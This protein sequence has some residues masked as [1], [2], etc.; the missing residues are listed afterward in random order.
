[1]IASIIA[2]RTADDDVRRQARI[3]QKRRDVLMEGLERIGWPADKPLASMFVWARV[4]D[5]HLA[6]RDSI[7]F[8]M[9]MMDEAEV[10]LAPGRAFG[11]NGE[12]YVRIAMVENELR[13]KQAFRQLDRALNKRPQ[14]KSPKSGK[15]K[16]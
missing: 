12:G 8:C 10:A 5:K 9:D 6:G 14:P 13:L 7:Q 16:S 2:M 11:E 1:Q 15:R 3:Y 4:P